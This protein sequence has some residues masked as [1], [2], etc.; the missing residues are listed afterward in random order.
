M[1]K[2]LELTIYPRRRV[3][4]E[5]FLGQPEHHFEYAVNGRLIDEQDIYPSIKRLTDAELAA[6]VHSQREAWAAALYDDVYARYV[7][8]EGE[9]TSMRDR[10]EMGEKAK[11]LH[12]FATMPHYDEQP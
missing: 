8:D 1:T 5:G 9:L 2:S 10:F 6:E 7:E 3:T 12:R 4:L 11:T